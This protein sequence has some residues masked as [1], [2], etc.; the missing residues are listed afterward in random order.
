MR[1]RPFRVA[2]DAR[3]VNTEHLRGI[4][5]SVFEL[6]KRTAASGA[7][8]WHLLADRPEKGPISVEPAPG[9]NR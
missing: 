7:V 4:G 9:V 8:D 3:S 2:V 6:V 5:K 1:D